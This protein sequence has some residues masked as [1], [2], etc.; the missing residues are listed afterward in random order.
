MLADYLLKSQPEWTPERISKAMHADKETW[1]NLKR[2]V[3]V[4]VTYFTAW[5]DNDGLLNFRDD[6]YGHDRQMAGLLFASVKEA[7]ETHAP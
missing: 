2:Q 1:V 7:H 4:A 3:P 6:I 5:V